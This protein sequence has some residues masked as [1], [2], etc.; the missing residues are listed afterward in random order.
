MPDKTLLETDSMKERLRISRQELDTR[1]DSKG[2]ELASSFKNAGMRLSEWWEL[3]AVRSSSG[4]ALPP[5]P[6]PSKHLGLRKLGF[7]KLL[8][9]LAP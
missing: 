9:L 6:G 8:P 5:S 1:M 2:N 3:Q 7:C 4:E